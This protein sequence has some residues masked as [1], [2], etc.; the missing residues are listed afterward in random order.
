MKLF[1]SPEVALRLDL[2]WHSVDV[3]EHYGCGWYGYCGDYYYHGYNWLTF[4]E[5]GLGLTFAL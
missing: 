3:G 5:A 2:R 4:T 1:F